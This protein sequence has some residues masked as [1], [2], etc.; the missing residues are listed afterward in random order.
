MGKFIE[1]ILPTLQLKLNVLKNTNDPREKELSLNHTIQN[2]EFAGQYIDLHHKIYTKLD[3]DFKV[4]CFSAD[5]IMDSTKYSGSNLP[6]MWATYG[7]N[8]KGICLVISK[9]EFEKENNIDNKNSTLRTVSYK[10]NLS[11][12]F[13]GEAERD[14]FNHDLAAEG[15]IEAN[16]E[17]IFY[18]KHHDWITECEVRLVT[19]SSSNYCSIKESLHKVI[20]GMDFPKEYLPAIEQPL[21]KINKREFLYV[22]ELQHLTGNLGETRI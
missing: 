2:I 12:I 18:T 6:R 7:D 13:N 14:N 11:N 5:Y 16:R 3:S 10:P 8:H 9:K 1:H 20:L 19:K 22:I 15:I 17:K 21:Q 4:C